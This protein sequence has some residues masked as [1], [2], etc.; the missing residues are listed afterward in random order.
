MRLT[1]LTTTIFTLFLFGA[2]SSYYTNKP[3]LG[4]AVI[5]PKTEKAMGGS[6][7]AILVPNNLTSRQNKLLNL[8]YK[9]AKEDGH[10]NPEVLQGIILQESKAGAHSSYKVAGQEFGL[11]ANQRYYGI[12]QIKLSAAKDVLTR[13][14]ELYTK[15]KFQT[16]TD[17]EIIANLILNE[18]FNIEI[19]SKYLI[20]LK[21][22]GY[23]STKQ[24]ANAYNQGPGGGKNVGENFH[25][26]NGVEKQI[27][28]LRK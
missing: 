13:F 26:G 9:K 22:Y 21:S 8:A 1:I 5:A 6:D 2:V 10:K 23:S 7:V 12:G 11:S 15:Y 24:L 20:I 18:E 3:A 4:T 25:Y 17:E 19:A 14:P 27:N 28:K 16:K